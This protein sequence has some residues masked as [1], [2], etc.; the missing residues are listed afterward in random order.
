QRAGI[1]L[2]GC[3]G[4]GL[5][6]SRPSRGDQVD[7]LANANSSRSRGRKS[8]PS[9]GG[10]GNRNFL[11]VGALNQHEHHGQE[12]LLTCRCHFVRCHQKRRS[13]QLRR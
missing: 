8:T 5:D 1:V 11:L 3:T 9:N 10:V 7:S 6:P 2:L 4:D 12:L 13:D